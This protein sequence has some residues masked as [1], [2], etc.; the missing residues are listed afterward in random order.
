[1]V[2][3]RNRG[4]EERVDEEERG[5]AEERDEEQ[6]RGAGGGMRSALLRMMEGVTSDGHGGCCS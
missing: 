1:M 4:F 2:M 5:E 6:R 3:R